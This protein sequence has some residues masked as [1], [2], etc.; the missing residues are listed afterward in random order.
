V[1]LFLEQLINAIQLG[2]MLFL[3]ASGLTLV[4]GIMNVINLAQGSLYMIGA[5][6]AATAAARGVPFGL[7][8]V[9][10]AICGGL[11]AIV[12]ELLLVRR[13]YARSH[14]DQ[15]LVT[16][17]VILFVNELA[18]IAWGRSPLFVATP[19]ALGGSVNIGGVPYPV[20]RLFVIALGLAVGGGLYLLIVKTRVGMLIRAGATHRELVE[21]LGVNVARL[22]T[23]VFGL[24]GVLAGIAGAAVGPI[25]S[26]GVGMGEQVLIQTFVVIVIGG[27][28]SIRG[29]FVAALLV[30]AID[31]FGRAYIPGFLGHVFAGTTAENLGAALSAVGIY[32][33]MAAVLIWR[34]RGL[35]PVATR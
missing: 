25:F 1:S 3:I 8:I 14:L 28:G 30:A 33:F 16:F 24:G 31:T 13:L 19:A 26:V 17:G 7:A 6:A 32:V 12:L 5:F 15:V 10:G 23:F 2:V 11:A 18:S 22:Y 35:F 20:Y 4:F 21:A 27:L 29:A 9:F 34:P